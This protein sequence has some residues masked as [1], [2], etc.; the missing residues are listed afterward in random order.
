MCGYGVTV[1]V[2]IWCNGECV[3]IWCNRACV[4]VCFV[5]LGPLFHLC[6]VQQHRNGWAASPPAPPAY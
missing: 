3:W 5:Q 1:R 6:L 2:W 4:C